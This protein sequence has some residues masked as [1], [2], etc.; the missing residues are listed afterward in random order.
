LARGRNQVSLL[1]VT[2]GIRSGKSR[3]GEELALKHERVLY[4][5]TGIGGD[6]EMARR[7]HLHKERR[8]AHWQTLETPHSLL[9]AVPAFAGFDA[10]LIDCLSGW[11]GNRL[12]RIPEELCGSAE[13]SGR[14]KAELAQWLAAIKP[15]NQTIIVISDEVGLGG[16]AMS[17]LGRWFQDLLG[18]A[19]Q[20]VA[21]AADEV[22]AVISG[23][24]VRIKG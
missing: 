14:L 8:P 19:N 7:I 9:E 24:P 12:V 10:V 21:Q 18:E 23:I 11:I 4:V 22:Y 20:Q 3:F 15:L 1:L 6:K 16:V 5:A 17:K 2:G 13:E